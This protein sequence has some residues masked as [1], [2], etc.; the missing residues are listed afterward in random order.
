MKIKRKG[1]KR[2]KPKTPLYLLGY[3]T[4]AP[5]MEEFTSWYNVEYGGPLQI[6]QDRK[7]TNHVIASH[8]P[9]SAILAT[10]LSTEGSQQLQGSLAWDHENVG[11]VTAAS[12]TSASIQDTILFA[13]RLARGFTLLT[14]GTTCDVLSQTYHNPSD[15]QDRSLA[16]FIVHDHIS[17]GLDEVSATPSS[18][19]PFEFKQWVYT[20]G[21]SK[22][23]LD[24]LEGFVPKGLPSSTMEEL[25]METADE[26][27][28]NGTT[29]KIGTDLRLPLLGRQVR[30]TKHRTAAPTGQMLGFREI[31]P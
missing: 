22:F 13:T 11:S 10:R 18:T 15:W 17:T 2:Q 1:P 12:A 20:L 9:W 4:S 25:L 28:R 26:I 21:L 19:E 14:Q 8:G 5:S 7:N 24:E 31:S 3:S 16:F 30:I 27:L 6:A 23:G 29:P